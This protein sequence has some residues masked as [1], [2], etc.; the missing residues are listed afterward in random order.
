[1]SGVKIASIVGVSAWISPGLASIGSRERHLDVVQALER[2][3][4]HD[5][6]AAG[7]DDRDLADEAGD[8]GRRGERRVRERALDA[9]RPVDDE[10]IDVEPLQRL[11]H[12]GS[13]ATVEGDALLDLGDARERA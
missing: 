7:L 11:H 5:D 10:R 8:A 2:G 13:R 1:M 4:A 9:E 6:D 12:R 3:L